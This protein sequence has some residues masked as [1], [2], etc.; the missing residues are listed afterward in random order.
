MRRTLPADTEH[1]LAEFTK[2]IATAIANAQA[3]EELRRVADEQAALRRVAT[4]VARAPPTEVFTA[5]AEEVGRVPAQSTLPR[6]DD[7]PSRRPSAGGAASGETAWW[8]RQFPSGATTRSRECSRP[9]GADRRS[10]RTSH[11]TTSARRSGG[12][13]GRRTYQRGRS[14]VGSDDCRRCTMWPSGTEAGAPSSPSSSRRPSRTPRRAR[15][16]V[17]SRTSR[18]RSG[19]WRRW[20]PRPRPPRQCSRQW[21]RSS[22]ASSR[23]TAPGVPVRRGQ[24]DGR[25]LEPRRG[26]PLGTPLR[27]PAQSRASSRPAVRRG[28]T[29]H[30]EAGRSAREG[31]AVRRRGADQRRGRLWGGGRRR[32]EAGQPADTEAR[33]ADFAELVAMAIANTEAR[34]ELSRVANEQAVLRRVATLVA[35]GAP[36]TD[37]FAAVAEEVGRLLSVEGALVVR[38]E[39]DA[40][41]TILAGR[42][43]SDRPLPIGLRTP[44]PSRAWAHS[45]GDRASSSHRPYADHPVALQYG[46]RSSAAAPITVQGR[47]WGYIGVTSTRE[48]P[49]PGT[50]ARLADF[51]ELVA[52]AIVNTEAR[53][54]LRRDRER[55]GGAAAG[56]DARRRGG[57]AT[58]S[59]RGSGGGGRSPPAHVDD[60]YVVLRFRRPRHSRRWSLIGAR[61]STSLRSDIRFNPSADRA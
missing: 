57:A 44:I 28:S 33:L 60:A 59:F 61:P 17:A 43:T 56:R 41:V 30:P 9:A 38:Y 32:G 12:F 6:Y 22:V 21:R 37:V 47:L 26:P 13:L 42:T 51:T 25:R 20:W 7:V 58:G 48:E 54:E 35:A 5:V 31:G 34:H 39:S 18:P 11:A 16:C 2:L 3:R 50:E 52:T 23:S 15:S 53:H 10:P 14:S 46:I 19:E 49:P 40:T 29:V 55:A 45:C 24:P 36:P 27:R 8:G 1:R 4:L